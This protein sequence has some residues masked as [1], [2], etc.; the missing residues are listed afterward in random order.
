MLFLRQFS[1]E[2]TTFQQKNFLQNPANY[3]QSNCFLFLFLK[4]KFDKFF[5]LGDQPKEEDSY[6][7][8][9]SSTSLHTSNTSTSALSSF[10]SAPS[11]INIVRRIDFLGIG[12][13]VRINGGRVVQIRRV[14]GQ[15]VIIRR[16]TSRRVIRSH[17]GRRW[18]HRRIT[19]RR[20]TR[21]LAPTACNSMVVLPPTRWTFNVRYPP[22]FPIIDI[23]RLMIARLNEDLKKDANKKS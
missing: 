1:C 12:T 18:I 6:Y 23:L 9:V 17:Q 15:D 10:S 2:K 13:R 7:E 8:D 16:A 11:P 5:L 3:F 4:C 20:I 21:P 22:N 19:R 14:V